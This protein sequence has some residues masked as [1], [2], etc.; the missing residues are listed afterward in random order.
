MRLCWSESLTAQEEAAINSA[1]QRIAVRQQQRQYVAPK[2]SNVLHSNEPT[3]RDV[4]ADQLGEDATSVHS[5]SHSHGANAHAVQ[6]GRQSVELT[7]GVSPTN[8]Q[9][10]VQ[11]NVDNYPPDATRD[12]TAGGIN[13]SHKPDALPPRVSGGGKSQSQQHINTTSLRRSARDRHS[14]RSLRSAND[15]FNSFV[16]DYLRE[17]A[18]HDVTTTAYSQV[19]GVAPVNRNY[20][21]TFHSTQY[22][23]AQHQQLMKQQRMLEQSRALHDAASRAKHQ[24]MIAQAHQAHRTN[25]TPQS[26]P[27]GSAAE[28]EQQLPPHKYAPKPPSMPSGDRKTVG[29]HRMARYATLTSV[30][31]RYTTPIGH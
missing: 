26:T 20:T 31:L 1:L 3:P 14:A 13:G 21:P 7:N 30:L 15:T 10:H 16:E 27:H 5:L 6:N 9:R 4:G 17:A 28:I 24:Q 8:H 19:T 11:S 29:A 2:G 18:T 22:Q 12:A 23:I 25:G